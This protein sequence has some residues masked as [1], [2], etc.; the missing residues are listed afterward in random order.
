[1]LKKS[2]FSPT[3]PRRLLHPPALRLPRQPLCQVK[4]RTFHQ[5]AFSLHSEARKHWRVFSVRQDPF[6]GRTATQSA[7]GTSSPLRSLRS[8]L[9]ERR[10]SVRQGWAGEKVAFLSILRGVLPLSFPYRPMNLH[11]ATLVFPAAYWEGDRRRSTT[12]RGSAG[13]SGKAPSAPRETENPAACVWPP[14]PK[15][16]AIAPTS[17][18]SSRERIL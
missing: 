15:D 12:N 4:G 13:L 11:R 18:P 8:C 14:P 6:Y 10:V 5:A 9:R 7:V 2:L 1:M 3:Q 17:I 16:A